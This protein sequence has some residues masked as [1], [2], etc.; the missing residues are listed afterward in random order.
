MNI[1][2]LCTGRCGSTTF[3]KACSHISNFT[4]AHESRAHLIG[5]DRLD[6]PTN[7]IE[8]D[9]RLSWLLGRLG[10]KYGRDAVYVHL[11]RNMRD[12]AHSFANGGGGGIIKAYKGSGIIMGSPRKCDPMAVALD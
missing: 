5:E 7:H 11:K 3:I 6:Y 10:R 1:F 4:S 12:T 2:V 8:A 9:N